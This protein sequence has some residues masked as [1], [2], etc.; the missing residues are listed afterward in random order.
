MSR[1]ITEVSEMLNLTPSAIRYYERVDLLPKI[2]RKKNGVR[3]YTDS[4]I[5]RLTLICCLKKTGMSIDDMRT[6]FFSVTKGIA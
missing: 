5:E 4:D 3:F 1:T 6:C 2:K